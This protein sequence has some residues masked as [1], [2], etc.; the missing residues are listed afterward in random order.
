MQT[1]RRRRL[2][3]RDDFTN[4]TRVF[5]TCW[6][7]L[8]ILE[9]RACYN[10][11]F[12]SLGLLGFSWN[13]LQVVSSHRCISSYTRLHWPGASR[14]ALGLKIMLVSF[15]LEESLVL[16]LHPFH[17]GT[18]ESTLLPRS[19]CHILTCSPKTSAGGT[20]AHE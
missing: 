1:R 8:V 14:K 2:T 10:N 11:V 15:G 19:S 20:L 12:L 7:Q 18:Q 6:L 3:C 13:S 4:Q 16:A 17:V 9:L 5:S